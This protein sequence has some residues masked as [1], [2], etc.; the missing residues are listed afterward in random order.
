MSSKKLSEKNYRRNEIT[1]RSK[2]S[3]CRK[4]SN[5]RKNNSFT[6]WRL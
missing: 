4:K 3:R 5:S 1:C 2:F 6:F